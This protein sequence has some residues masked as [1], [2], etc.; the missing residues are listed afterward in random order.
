MIYHYQALNSKGE[1]VSDFLD[2][3]SEQAA[4]SKIRSLG[5]YVVRINKQDV[6]S[7]TST[8]EKKA[9]AGLKKIFNTF[10]EY[11]NIK[12]SAKLVGL[13]TRQLTTLLKAGMPL[14]SAITDIIDQIDNKSFRHIIIDI[15]EKLEEGLSLSNALLRHRAVFSDMYINMVRVGENLGSLDEVTARLADIEEKRN[16]LTGKVRA[17]L[18]YPAFMFLFAIAVLIFLMV[19]VIPNI[20]EMFKSQNRELPLPTTIVIGMSDFL[21]SFWYVIPLFVF[22]IIYLYNRM[23][24]NREGRKK[25]D[26]IKLNIPVI[27]HLYLKIIVLKFTQNLGILLNNKVDIIKSFDIVQKIVGNV[28]IEEKIAEAAIKIKEGATVSTALQKGDFLPKLVIGMISAGEASDNLDKMLLNIAGVYET[29]IDLTVSSLTSLLEPVIIIIM[30][31][32]IGTI[33]VSVMLPIMQ[34][35]LLVQ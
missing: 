4:R 18:W 33:V 34:M 27:K 12:L 35:N 19:N 1:T 15:K 31:F 22:I 21:S 7:S 14:L 28:I 17:A 24:N 32:M 25:I 23:N 3:P 10:L 8:G 11:I 6:S 29:E 20:A 13:F 26:G 5:F 2:A 16:A 30:G 9:D